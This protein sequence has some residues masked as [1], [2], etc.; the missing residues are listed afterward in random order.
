MQQ[1]DLLLLADL[2]GMGETRE[3]EE[4]NAWKFYNREYHNAMTSIHLGKNLVGQRV[5]DLL[6]LV[7]FAAS[8]DSGKDA[9]VDL[10]ASGANAPVAIYA[11]LFRPQIQSIQASN[12]IQTYFEV[13]NHPME[14]D[15]YSYVIPHVLAYF[16][17]PDLLKLRNDLQVTWQ[18]EKSRI[19]DHRKHKNRTIE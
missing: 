3:A 15:W 16:D 13:L 2:R 7:D 10:Y 18:G 6:T 19:E 9:P 14:V 1:G 5:T 12:S 17:L 8:F 4:A 11:A